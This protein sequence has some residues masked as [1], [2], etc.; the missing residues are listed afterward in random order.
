MYTE[1]T[2]VLLLLF[3]ILHILVNNFETQQHGN[4]HSEC[5]VQNHLLYTVYVR[6]S[7]F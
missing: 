3:A 2:P 7:L 6:I 1:Y 4:G 5:G